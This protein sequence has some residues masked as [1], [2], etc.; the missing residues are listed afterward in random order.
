VW[1]KLEFDFNV[2]NAMFER[3]FEDNDQVISATSLR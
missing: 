2:V 1:R 3:E